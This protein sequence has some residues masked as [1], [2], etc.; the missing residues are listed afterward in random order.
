VLLPEFYSMPPPR[1]AK[2]SFLGKSPATLSAAELLAFVPLKDA[3]ELGGISEDNLRK[4]YPE[5][6]VQLS[7][8]RV[9]IRLHHVLK[10]PA[11]LID[12]T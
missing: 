4:N 5:L 2:P 12:S 6:I 9:G 10:L 1:K 3:E 7:P 11:P 8:G